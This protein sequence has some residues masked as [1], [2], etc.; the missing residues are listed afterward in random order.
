MALIIDAT[1]AWSAPVSIASDELWQARQGSIYLTTSNAPGP[2]DG[3]SLV[4]GQGIYVKAGSAVKYRRQGTAL[5]VIA[6]EAL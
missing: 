6:R 1:S 2:D 3:L 5:A 4:E